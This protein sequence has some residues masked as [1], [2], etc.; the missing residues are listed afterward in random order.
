MGAGCKM[1]TVCR[2]VADVALWM[3]RLEPPMEVIVGTVSTLTK[4]DKDTYI[5]LT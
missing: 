4:V 2:G 5:G 3:M 1:V